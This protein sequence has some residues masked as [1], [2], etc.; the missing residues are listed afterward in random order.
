[1]ADDHWNPFSSEANIN[2]A[3]WFFRNKVGKLQIDAYFAEGL[4]GTVSR[5][6]GATYTKRHHLHALDP[7]CDYLLWTEPEIND[8]R[9]V[10]AFYYR[11]IIDCLC[12]LICQVV[13]RS[14]I[15]Y[16]PIR[17]NNSSGERLYSEMHMADWWWETQVWNMLRQASR[18]QCY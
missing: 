11:N 17:E 18:G 13:Y 7:F 9:H 14:D 6:F 5:S 4:G 3:S 2:L 12:Y 8:G 15:V 1:M 16:E 10:T